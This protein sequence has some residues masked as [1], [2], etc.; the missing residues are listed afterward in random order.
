MATRS[1]LR[2]SLHRFTVSGS[3]SGVASFTFSVSGNGSVRRVVVKEG[4]GGGATETDIYF[5]SMG[6]TSV[7]SPSTEDQSYVI[8]F[9][10]DL[11]L[12]ASATAVSLDS[13]LSAEPTFQDTLAAVF[14]VTAVGDWTI[15]GYIEIE[16]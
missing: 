14:D 3:G 1:G 13:P 12:T 9:I 6:L 4:A 2:R 5:F 7:T 11:V 10:E 16:A 15:T 8:I